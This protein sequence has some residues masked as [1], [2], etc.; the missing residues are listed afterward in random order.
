MYYY[1]PRITSEPT[2]GYMSYPSVADTFSECQTAIVGVEHDDVTTRRIHHRVV[3]SGA[4]IEQFRRT[5]V[6]ERVAWY[7]L[8]RNPYDRN[9]AARVAYWIFT[10]R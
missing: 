4:Y 2:H 6:T 10:C 1:T 9:R 8:L 7:Q 3:V 5:V